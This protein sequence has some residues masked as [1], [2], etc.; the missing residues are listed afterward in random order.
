MMERSGIFSQTVVRT[1]LF[2]GGVP[3]IER[4][5]ELKEIPW[6]FIYF[7]CKNWGRFRTR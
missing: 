2:N 5:A 7:F 3:L 6:Q 1:V 4:G